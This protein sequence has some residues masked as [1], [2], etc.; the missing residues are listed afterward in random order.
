MRYIGIDYG[1]KRI[2]VA[3]S[4]E[5][6][7]FALPHSVIKNTKTALSELNEIICAN[8]VET[9]VL[10]E[11]KNYHG[12]DNKVMGDIRKFKDE[13]ENKL[14]KRVVFEPEM[15]TSME[16]E[17]IQGKTKMLDASAAALILKSYL[18]RLKNS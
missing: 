5:S 15:M 2:G 13:I 6:N 17:H 1:T 8:D 11:S 10:G 18:D 12:E 16:A 9:V 4:D 7:S 3:L 14:G